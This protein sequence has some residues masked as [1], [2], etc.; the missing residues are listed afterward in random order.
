LQRDV[1]EDE[2]RPEV[3]VGFHP[4]GGAAKE[5]DVEIFGVEPGLGKRQGMGT[6]KKR[7]GGGEWG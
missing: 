6:G 3:E 5:L 1:V 7:V 4:C 2:E